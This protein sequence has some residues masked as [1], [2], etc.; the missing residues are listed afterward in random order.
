[1]VARQ[2][3]AATLRVLSDDFERE[4]PPAEEG[5][6]FRNQETARRCGIRIWLIERLLVVRKFAGGRV[7]KPDAL[8][9]AAYIAMSAAPRNA[10][11]RPGGDSQHRDGLGDSNDLPGQARTSKDERLQSRIEH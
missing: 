10:G 2:E 8:V 9:G 3:L 5:R 7:M 1:M 11:P 4:P 6:A